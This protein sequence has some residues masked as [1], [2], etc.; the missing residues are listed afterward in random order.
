MVLLEVSEV[1][2]TAG[3]RRRILPAANRLADFEEGITR[4]YPN[5]CNTYE[6]RVFASL[7]GLVRA[8]GGIGSCVRS[9]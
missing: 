8:G 7:I 9:R 6:V 3:P 1:N 4:K 5:G 2:L